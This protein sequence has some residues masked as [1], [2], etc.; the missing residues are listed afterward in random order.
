MPVLGSMYT[1]FSI[2]PVPGPVPVFV[3]LFANSIYNTLPSNIKTATRIAPIFLKND[4]PKL[5]PLNAVTPLS[6]DDDK[7]PPTLLAPEALASL[8]AVNAFDTRSID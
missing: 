3:P 2:R 6:A 7:N 5:V 1:F 4:S 8:I